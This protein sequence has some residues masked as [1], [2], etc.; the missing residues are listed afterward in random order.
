MAPE[1]NSSPDAGLCTGDSCAARFR[2]LVALET[3]PTLAAA[4]H[5]TGTAKP[6]KRTARSLGGV[7][8]KQQRPDTRTTGGTFHALTATILVRREG[9]GKNSTLHPKPNDGGAFFVHLQNPR[10]RARPT[11]TDPQHLPFTNGGHWCVC[12]G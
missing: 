11:M 2:F 9:V 5:G 6:A 10:F 12:C 7:G 8:R 4:R 1:G 3:S